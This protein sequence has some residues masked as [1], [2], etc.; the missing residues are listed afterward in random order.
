MTP[1]DN[2]ILDP[3]G[4]IEKPVF[5][6][7]KRATLD[8][9]RKGP[10]LF[11]DNTKLAFCYY[12]E[13][14]VAL[15]EFFRS[16]GVGNFVDFRETVRGKNSQ[17][18]RVYAKKLADSGAVAA[19][20]ALGDMGTTP[21]TTVLAIELERLGVPTVY[22][23]ASPGAEV[24]EACAYYQAGKLC[25]CPI[26]I[27]QGSSKD[28]IRGQVAAKQDYILAALTASGAALEELAKVHFSLDPSLPLGPSTLTAAAPRF[29]ADQPAAALEEIMDLW[30]DLHLGDGLP[31][32]PPTPKR[33]DAM[34]AYCPWPVDTVLT[35][36][37]GPTG[38][39]ITVWD[40]AIAAVMAGCKP[41]Y[42]PI[43]ITAF[44]A[45]NDVRYN[46]LQSVTTSHPG[47]NLVLVSGPLAR[48]IGIH[49]GPGCLGPGFRANAT[50]GRAVNL[51]VLNNCRSVPGVCDLACVSSQA[52]YTYCFAEDARLTP[53]NTMNAERYDAGATCVYA[54]KAEPP[55]D[56][57]DFLS[58]TGGDFLDTVVDCCTTLGSNNAY[59]PGNLILVLTPDHAKL[60][61]RDGYD[62]KTIRE[63]IHQRAAHPAPMVR[64]RGLV[65]VRPPDFAGRHPMPVTRTPDD[66]EVIVAGGRGGHS[67]VILP[68]ALH[69]EAVAEKVVLPDGRTPTSI[70][71]LRR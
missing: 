46:V 55:H 10:V 26:D 3:R 65:P 58:Q 50:I 54:V 69:S 70:E 33:L 66:I 8:A 56:I 48:E 44:H 15:K 39:N 19:I 35:R 53:W 68:W 57:I 23:T 30:D 1:R 67:A 43:L 24:A 71:D 60:L 5:E 14:F 40:V 36:E 34:L 27:Y 62:K 42:L 64:N 41:Q 52:E 21:A 47:G 16:Q 49:G 22:I 37:A 12:A 13:I 28:D 31:I 51:V 45:M 7:A 61:A 9:L 17:A 6:L 20:V 4:R 32:V 2:D 59:I 38:K 25:L 18:L 11:Y 29:G 63:Q